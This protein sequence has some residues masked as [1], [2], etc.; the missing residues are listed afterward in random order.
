M[1][2]EDTKPEQV[3][4][5]LERVLEWRYA[6]LMVSLV[7]AIDVARAPL[8]AIGFPIFDWF[9]LQSSVPLGTVLVF[10]TVYVF[11]S[12]G[13]SLLLQGL[14]EYLLAELG[15]RW[16][17]RRW[18]GRKRDS[19]RAARMYRHGYALVSDVETLALQQR[20]EFWIRRVNE[21]RAQVKS[22]ERSIRFMVNLSFS[23]ALLIFLECW[24]RGPIYWQYLITNS[25]SD[26]SEILAS[27]F[28]I[29]MGLVC[30]TLVV[31]PWWN[32]FVNDT[33]DRRWMEHPELAAKACKKIDEERDAEVA[34]QRQM[35]AA[36][37]DRSQQELYQR[38]QSSR[39]LR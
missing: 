28:A 37:S 27:I 26:V 32:H 8:H 36:K 35:H 13:L 30:L 38:P 22:K 23:C 9:A 12:S 33:D 3:L 34:F 15:I 17:L 18:F 14:L 5:L 25:S 6:L 4:P 2:A 21:D 39:L 7:L 19:T 24:V 10:I 29:A 20:D 16:L 11:F 31:W 1:T